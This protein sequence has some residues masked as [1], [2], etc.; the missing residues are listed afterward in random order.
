[1]TH[2]S[3]TLDAK[4]EVA[5]GP[6]LEPHCCSKRLPPRSEEAGVTLQ[7]ES[8]SEIQMII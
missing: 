1:M 3:Q 2:G 6:P 8:E 4:A 5:R 7:R